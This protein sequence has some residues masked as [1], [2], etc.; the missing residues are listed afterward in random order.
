M[1]STRC[2]QVRWGRMARELSDMRGLEVATVP[3]A[4]WGH[5]NAY[6][7]RVLAEVIGQ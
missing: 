6:D 2:G 3:D 1:T 4:R 7:M 5:V